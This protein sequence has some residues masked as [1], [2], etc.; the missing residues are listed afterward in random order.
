MAKL[1]ISKVL[2]TSKL[3]ATQA[4]QQ[5]SEL[6]T[7]TNDMSEQVVRALR[8]GLTF[9]DNFKALSATISVTHNTEQIVETN[10]RTP[11]YVLPARVVSSTVGID[12]FT[13]FI[14]NSNRLVVKVGFTS[15]AP[16]APLNVAILIFFQ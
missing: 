9:D 8:Q 10:N 3:L 5:L 14:D 16:T 11:V 2:E 12:A 6:I 1:Q 15:P 4:G 7:F 13:W